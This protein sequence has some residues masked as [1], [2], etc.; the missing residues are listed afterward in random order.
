VLTFDGGKKLVGLGRVD[1][2]LESGN[3]FV[4]RFDDAWDLTIEQVGVKLEHAS[5]EQALA[6]LKEAMPGDPMVQELTLEG[7][8]R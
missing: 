5:F 8:A 1:Y 2:P 4:V 7:E 3:L 6:A